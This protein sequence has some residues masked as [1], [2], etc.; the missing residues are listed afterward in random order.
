MLVFKKAADLQDYL[1]VKKKAGKTLGF[2]P[3]MGAL[4]TGHISLVKQAKKENTICCVSIFVNPTQFNNADDLKK[5]PRKEEEDSALLKAA[6]CDVIFIPEVKEMYPIEDSRIFDLGGLDLEMEGKFR[7]GHFNGVA[8]I[9]SKLF[10]IVKPHKAYFG[11]KDFQ[12]L[13]ILRYLNL[14]Y[15]THLNILIVACDTVREA[16]G[17]A[18]SSRNLLLSHSERKSAGLISKNLIYIKEH[19]RDRSVAELKNMFF[20]AVD[21]DPNLKTEYIE[22]VNDVT[23]K[24]VEHIIAG[25]TTAC[26][27]VYC[28]N[29]RLI[30]NIPF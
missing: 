23:L 7:K 24:P 12:Q 20:E 11:R 16:D 13:A 22:I 10:E 1:E 27:A 14:H 26:A 30:D 21:Q 4:H 29:V 2:V 15:L 18:M 6:G 3:T 8:Q 19:Y 17:L 28:G 9:V 25:K 5:Y